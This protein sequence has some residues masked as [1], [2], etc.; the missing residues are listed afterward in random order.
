[1]LLQA[2]LGHADQAVHLAGALF[3]RDLEAAGFDTRAFLVPAAQAAALAGQH[4]EAKLFLLDSIF[5]LRNAREVQRAVGHRAA[6]VVGGPNA[7]QHMLRGS[8]P[9]V[10]DGAGRRAVVELARAVRDAVEEGGGPTP[11]LHRL[12]AVPN[13]YFR[14]SSG[15]PRGGSEEGTTSFDASAMAHRDDPATELFPYRPDLRWE[16]PDPDRD[17]EAWR[18]GPSVVAAFGCVYNAAVPGYEAP[19]VPAGLTERAAQRYRSRYLERA[20]GC[21]FCSFRYQ[22]HRPLPRT[23]IVE[24]LATQLEFLR[25][26]VAPAAVSL[27]TEDPFPVLAELVRWLGAEWPGLRELRIRSLV[28]VILGREGAL[29]EA[30]SRARETGLRIVLQQVGYESFSDAEL[31]RYNKGVTAADNLRCARLLDDLSV[32]HPSAFDGRRGHGMILLGPWTELADL[33][34]TLAVGREFPYLLRHAG[35]QQRL[36]LYADFHPIALRA[37]DEGL[38]WRDEAID[39]FG[40]PWRFADPRTAACVEAWEDVVLRL[41]RALDSIRQAT[42]ERPGWAARLETIESRRRLELMGLLV[43][44]AAEWRGGEPVASEVE[45]IAERVCRDL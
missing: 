9:L 6:V 2:E 35:P 19:P 29:R 40:L 24:L 13:L 44:A 15:A 20:G 10:V 14:A 26:E 33:R 3:K 8:V 27:Q 34:S 37:L 31:E 1:V 4:G 25:D 12:E 38:A 18:N 36:E 39:D 11:T 7:V 17:P 5:P 30:V 28:K 22:N 45:G 32:S 42:A 16:H 43:Q 21:T 23:Q 41:S